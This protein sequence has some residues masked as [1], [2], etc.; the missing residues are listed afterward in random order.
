MTQAPSNAAPRTETLSGGGY[1]PGHP[2][3]YFLGGK[4]L[5][6]KSILKDVL[7]SGYRGYRTDIDKALSLVEPK[8]SEMLRKIR[9]NVVLQYHAD[10]ERYREVIRELQKTPIHDRR[11]D[12][13]VSSAPVHTSASLKYCHLY[14]DL[15]HLI[16]ID[17]ALSVQGD[18]FG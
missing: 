5:G 9:G 10:L 6:P 8:R 11:P 18:L 2:W 15:A 4:V 7:A 1:S 13:T 12:G 14:N 17:E 16:R 3:Y